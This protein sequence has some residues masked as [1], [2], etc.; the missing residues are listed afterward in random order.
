MRL[1]IIILATMALC[2]SANADDNATVYNDDGET[3]VIRDGASIMTEN[4]WRIVRPQAVV[5][6]ENGWRNCNLIEN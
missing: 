2:G 1:I 3:R 4:G 6:T 5:M